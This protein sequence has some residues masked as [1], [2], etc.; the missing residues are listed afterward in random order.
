MGIITGKTT[1]FPRGIG[2]AMDIRMRSVKIYAST[3]ADHR[4]IPWAHKD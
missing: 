2:M 3:T 1:R 4:I